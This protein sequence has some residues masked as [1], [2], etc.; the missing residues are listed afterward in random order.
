MRSLLLAILVLL[1]TLDAYSANK[2]LRILYVQ[3]DASMDK[4]VL[5]ERMFTH[6]EELKES[7]FAI[8]FANDGSILDAADYSKNALGVKISNLSPLVVSTAQDELEKVSTLLNTKMQF[9]I[10]TSENGEKQIES[11]KK[12]ESMTVDLFVGDEFLGNGKQNSIIAKLI[13][14]NSLD[15]LQI[16]TSF[17]VSVVYYPCGNKIRMKN[18]R[19]ETYYNIKEPEISE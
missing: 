5:R 12:Y 8:Y 9:S 11:L 18:C 14:S 4:Q 17:N 16:G 7:D 19:F 15:G 13:C 1:T 6:I 10:S 3:Y 2:H